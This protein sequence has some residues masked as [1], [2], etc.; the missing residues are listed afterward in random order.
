M[1][2]FAGKIRLL[3]VEDNLNVM[4]SMVDMFSSPLFAI[5]TVDSVAAA[6]KTIAAATHPW[7]CWL[8]DIA[9]ETETAGL[10]LV[11][12]AKGFP[13][14]IML[15]GLKS[16][17]LASQAVELGAFKVFDKNPANLLDVY[18]TVCKVAVLGFLL[19][20]KNTKNMPAFTVLLKKTI[21]DTAE[22]ANAAVITGRHLQRVCSAD[23]IAV[24]RYAI[25][26]FYAVYY[27]LLEGCGFSAQEIIP[28]REHAFYADCLN[29]VEKNLSQ[30]MQATIV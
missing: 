20:G 17:S 7:H 15:S 6:Y 29:S 16:M 3:M 2:P 27:L 25:S 26:L 30:I 28:A 8:C 1:L 21:T 12:D 14:I 4:Q 5:T 24:P 10:D 9:L 18:T 13:F 22:W 23:A 19:Q 11:R